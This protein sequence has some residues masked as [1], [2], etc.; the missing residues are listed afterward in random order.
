MVLCKVTGAFGL[1]E[2][3][4]LWNGCNIYGEASMEWIPVLLLY[5]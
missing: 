3:F 4:I 5:G 1:E 2:L